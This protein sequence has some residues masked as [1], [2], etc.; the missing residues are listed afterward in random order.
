[1]VLFRSD[2]ADVHAML[3][4]RFSRPLMHCCTRQRKLALLL[5]MLAPVAPEVLAQVTAAAP[6]TYILEGSIDGRDNHGYRLLPFQVSA[7]T[8]RLTI[9]IAYTGA[10]EK[11]VIDIGLLDPE[12]FRGARRGDKSSLT[13][14]ATGARP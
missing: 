2:R 12:R 9:Q 8:G 4:S 3:G 1:R 11:T 6:P 13:I 14:S 5:L 10:D 7:G